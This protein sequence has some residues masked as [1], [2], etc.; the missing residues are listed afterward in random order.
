MG[1]RYKIA[2]YSRDSCTYVSGDDETETKHANERK[3]SL[4]PQARG[5]HYHIITL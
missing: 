3:I 5:A 1:G 2:P 4:L